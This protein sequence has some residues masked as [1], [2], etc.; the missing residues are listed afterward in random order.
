MTT[1]DRSSG[2]EAD[3]RPN[4]GPGRDGPGAAAVAY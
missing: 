2:R 4:H 1:S 3:F